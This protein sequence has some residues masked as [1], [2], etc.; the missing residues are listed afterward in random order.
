MKVKLPMNLPDD[1]QALLDK[2]T[3]RLA[4]VSGV[5]AVALGGSC[6]RGMQRAGSDLDVA[7]YY[8]EIKPFSIKDIQIVANEISS[9]GPPD[10][11]DFY[12][13]GAWVNGGAWIQTAAGKVD[14]LYRNLDQ[15]Q[16]TLDEA[17]A[18]MLRHDYDQQPAFGFYSV[19]YLAETKVCLPLYDPLGRITRLKE[20]V[21]AY[22]PRLKEQT[23]SSNLWA[24]E[25]SLLHASGYAR[26]GDVY[27]TTGALGRAAANLTQALFALN[28]TYFMNDKTAMQEL[29]AFPLLPPGCVERLAA[30]LGQAGR[31]TEELGEST[32]S[33]HGLWAEVV[34]LSG[35]T[36]R[37]AFRMPG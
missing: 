13:W 28:E 6:A 31:S 1:K 8:T 26:N 11:T 10:V 2:I 7:M 24:A 18:G 17:R 25:F 16:R 32:R 20:Q 35:G 5:Q 34:D 19:I 12:G 33:L 14:F 27:A 37:P 30:I 4:G 23:V 21:A 36:Y 3:A 9:Q 15:V 22:P 29:A